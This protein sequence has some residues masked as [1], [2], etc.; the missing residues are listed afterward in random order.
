MYPIVSHWAWSEQG[1][2]AQ[3]LSYTYQNETRYAV[4]HDFAGSGAVHLLAGLA[5][6]VGATFLGPRLGRFDKT[7]NPVEMRGHSMP[8][9][10][11]LKVSYQCP[12]LLTWINFN[13]GTDK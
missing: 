5:A 8:V 11:A 13:P 7:G 1:W 6:L 12:L 4:Y 10:D 9:S 2:L 3:R